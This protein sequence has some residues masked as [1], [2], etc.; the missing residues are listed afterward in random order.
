MPVIFPER[1]WNEWMAKLELFHQ[2]FGHC[3]VPVR[4]SS[5]PG[6]AR[7]VLQQRTRFDAL[8]LERLEQLYRF[9]FD[10]GP[11]RYWLARFFELV[12]FKREHGH[13]DVPAKWTENR[14]LGGWLSGQRARKHTMPVRRRKLFESIGLEWAPL[15]AAWNRHYQ[16]LIAFKEKFGHCNVPGEWEE[17]PSLGL[18]VSNQRN[19]KR[20]LRPL[21]KRLLKRLGFD[22]SPTETLWKTHLQEL[23]VFRKQ[24]GD[25]NVPPKYPANPTLGSWV[26]ELRQRG[27]SRVPKRWKHRLAALEFDWSPART[28]WWETRFA[29]LAAFKKQF[30]HCRVPKQLPPNPALG[31]W[32][33]TQRTQR[34]K[35]SPSR[36]RRLKALGFEWQLKPM[37]PAKTWEERFQELTDFH[38]RFGHCDVP[39]TWPENQPL[40]EWVKRQRGRDQTKLTSQL[41]RRLDELGFCWALRESDWEQRFSELR[42]FWLKHG[43]CDV[44]RKWSENPSLHGWILRQRYRKHTL[45]PERIRKLDE[46]SFRWPTPEEG[47]TRSPITGRFVVPGHASS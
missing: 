1:E 42:F 10:I 8:P 5:D 36:R 19:R 17:N 26:A 18:W 40:S 35:L 34:A 47:T 24:R 30:G 13:C 2:T 37:S 22:W 33:S 46:L 3:R 32:V 31:D 39:G 4:W 6:L 28:Q 43:H 15:D 38:K 12:E 45:S 29:E 7:W 44:P 20:R 16:D 27:Q 14:Q 9:G 11:D 25:C 41:R 21:Q 23:R